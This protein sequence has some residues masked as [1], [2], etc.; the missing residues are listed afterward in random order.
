[1]FKLITLLTSIL[2]VITLGLSKTQKK[3]Q[4]ITIIIF[5]VGIGSSYSE[6]TQQNIMFVNEAKQVP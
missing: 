6:W 3:N 5:L 1:M 2:L 4:L